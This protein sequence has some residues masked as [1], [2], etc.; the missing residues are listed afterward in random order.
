MHSKTTPSKPYW[1][2]LKSLLWSRRYIFVVRNCSLKLCI[3]NLLA[4]ALLVFF[5][6]MSQGELDNGI[7]SFAYCTVMPQSRM[8]LSTEWWNLCFY[9]GT[10]SQSQ[11]TNHWTLSCLSE[12]REYRLSLHWNHVTSSFISCAFCSVLA[13]PAPF[14]ISVRVPVHSVLWT[15]KTDIAWN[16][17]THTRTPTPCH[18]SKEFH[19][20]SACS[21]K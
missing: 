6:V 13:I 7:T 21:W 12:Q 5:S 2:V 18:S 16:T 20:S 14:S 10:I 19:S 15:F 4:N 17:H 11:L 1:N 9:G 8:F 3:P